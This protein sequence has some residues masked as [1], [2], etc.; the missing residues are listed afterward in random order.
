MNKL[1]VKLFLFLFLFSKV[2]LEEI[3]IGEINISGLKSFK[4]NILFINS[5]L[6]PKEK[7]DDINFVD[8]STDYY[9]ID[10]PLYQFHSAQGNSKKALYYLTAA[11][12]HIPEDERKDYL[13]DDKRMEHLHKYYYIHEIIEEYNQHIR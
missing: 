8:A 5:G 4:E 7:Y 3:F 6:Y 9:Y 1:L 11:Y 10:W 13:T 12:N 2:Y